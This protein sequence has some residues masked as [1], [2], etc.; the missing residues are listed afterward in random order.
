MSKTGRGRAVEALV[1]CFGEIVLQFVGILNTIEAPQACLQ[2]NYF[3]ICL[4]IYRGTH[5]VTSQLYDIYAPRSVGIRI[6]MDLLSFLLLDPDPHGECRSRCAKI[7]Q[8]V[9][10]YHI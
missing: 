7:Y 2:T 8:K 5:L 10:K 6:H 1:P 3:K 4:R 9:K